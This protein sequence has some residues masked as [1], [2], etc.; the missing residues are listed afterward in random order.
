MT[1]AAALRTVRRLAP[2]VTAAMGISVVGLWAVRRVVPAGAVRAANDVVGNY[3]QTLGTVYA[4]L[5]AFVVFVVW[6]QFNEVRTLIDREANEAQDLHRTVG[7]LPDAVRAHVQSAVS[8][9]VHAVLHDEWPA[10]DHCHE[11]R[12]DGASRVLEDAWRRLCA[13]EPETEVQRALYGEALQRFNDLS[14]ARTLR[15]SAASMRIPLALRMLLYTGAAVLVASM[16]LFDV[17]GFRVHAMITAALAGSL[18]HLLYIV[19][20]LDRPFGGDWQVP[21][22][23][24]ERLARYIAP[25]DGG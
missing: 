4:V 21:R 5:L 10:M 13:F 6:S 25:P 20:D 9:Y 8:R 11:A 12:F 16:Y 7:G 1:R 23:S 19:E 17:P 22:D 14:D 18:S 2:P 15:R 3:L 24:W